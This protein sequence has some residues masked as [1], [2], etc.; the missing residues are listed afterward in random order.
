MVK[1][2][3]GFF[4]AKSFI[5]YFKKLS[6]KF[7]NYQVKIKSMEIYQFKSTKIIQMNLMLNYKN[8]CKLK[9]NKNL[10]NH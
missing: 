9:N 10:Y 1:M 2:I 6:I 8:I 3:D 7:M 5:K 4:K